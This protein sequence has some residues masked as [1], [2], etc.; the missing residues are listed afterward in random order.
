MTKYTL[1]L[2]TE[3]EFM[4]RNVMVKEYRNR[5]GVAQRVPGGFGSQISMKFGT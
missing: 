5:R 1:I 2:F 3:N 4:L